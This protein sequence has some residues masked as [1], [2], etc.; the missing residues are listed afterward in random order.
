MTARFDST[1]FIG[2][3]SSTI[4]SFAG[5]FKVPLR[6]MQLPLALAGLVWR[7]LLISEEPVFWRQPPVADF[8]PACDARPRGLGG[9]PRTGLPGRGQAAGGR[10]TGVNDDSH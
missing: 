2:A 9:G 1:G 10:E 7:T 3:G 6:R 8:V 5:V 4:G